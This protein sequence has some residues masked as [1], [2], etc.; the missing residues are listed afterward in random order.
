MHSVTNGRTHH[1]RSMAGALTTMVRRSGESPPMAGTAAFVRLTSDG[2]GGMAEL[3][4]LLGAQ[5][6]EV[7]LGLEFPVPVR[8]LHEGDTLFHEGAPAEGIY[9]VRAGT[10]KTFCTGEDGYEQVLGFSG[11]GDLLGFDAIGLG[12]YVNQVVALEE[13]S[14]Y[15]VLLRDYLSQSPRN[16]VLDRAVFRAVSNALHQRGEVA[17]MMAAVAAEVRL[18]RFLLHLSRRMAACGLSARRFHLRMSRRDIASYLGVA[19]ET[20]SRAFT[21]L[22]ALGMVNVNNREVE[23]ID[24]VALRAF[25]TGTRRQVDDG[26]RAHR[27]GLSTDSSGAIALVA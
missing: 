9:F 27:A 22:V 4:R 6:G 3:L 26:A 21:S 20:V 25:S 18:T 17:D 16:P 12:H 23:I 1:D 15:V 8:R 13:S 5:D 24:M 2:Q 14:V 19:H 11:R 7:G 10:F